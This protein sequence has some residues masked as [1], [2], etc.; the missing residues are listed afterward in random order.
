MSL[1]SMWK[2]RRTFAECDAILTAPGMPFETETRLVNGQVQR[3][4]KHL[5]SSIREFWLFFSSQHREKT[6]VVYEDRRLSYGDVLSGSQHAARIFER[7]YGVRKGDRV[8]ICSRNLPEYLVAFWACHL[9]GAVSVMVNA[10][11][12]F[13][14]LTYCLEKADSRLILV[15]A[16]RA[17]IVAPT[18]P[19]LRRDGVAGVLVWDTEVLHAGWDGLRLWSDVM[20]L[21]DDQLGLLEPPH[22]ENVVMDPEDDATIFFTSGTTGLP[23]GVL[24]TQ[25]Q[26]LTNILNARIG[27]LRTILR[28]GDDLPAVTESKEPQKA[29]LISVPFFHVA[30]T[31]SLTMLA[32]SMGMKIILMRKWDM[33]KAVSLVRAENVRTAGGVP[34]IVA[35]LLDSPLAGHPFET[36]IFGGSPAHDRLPQMARMAWPSANMSQTYGLTEANSISV[37]I[38]GKDYEARPTSTG[39]PSVVND[40]LIVRNNKT[41]P[42]GEEGEIWLRGPN[43]MKCYW[44]DPEATAKALTPDGWLKTGDLGVL[45]NEGFL[46]IRDRIKDLINRGGENI[47]STSVENA[48]HGD[49][50]INQVAAVGVPDPRLGELVAAV[51][52]PKASHRGQVKG[53]EIIEMVRKSLP[54]YAVPVMVVVVDEPFELTPSHKIK[55]EPLR[56]LA[57]KE[58]ERRQSKSSQIHMQAR[59]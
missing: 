49:D 5:Y 3:V 30:G 6:Y 51:V 34:A 4:Y 42:N 11:L 24:S 23:K 48:I 38:T 53:E 10:W 59:L 33:V 56:A 20:R 21:R 44:K 27:S 46:Y 28:N 18:I 19:N 41:V 7:V 15:D 54:H 14:P 8:A 40:L 12:P 16:E 39:L 13:E 32:T 45:D 36:L 17:D 47:D 35:D 57:R 29:V 37:S 31:T 52:S 58:W 2:P 22:V 1:S 25:R 26:F 50:R 9:I 43:V 55:K